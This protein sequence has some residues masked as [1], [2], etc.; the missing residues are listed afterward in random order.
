M[1][2]EEA[3]PT[4]GEYQGKRIVCAALGSLIFFVVH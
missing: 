3:I 1:G 4:G 2:T